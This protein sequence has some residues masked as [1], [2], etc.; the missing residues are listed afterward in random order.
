MY[1]LRKI[2]NKNTF[3]YIQHS[4]LRFQIVLFYN[5]FFVQA[6]LLSSTVEPGVIIVLML[7]RLCRFPSGT[8]PVHSLPTAVLS[9]RTQILLI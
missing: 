4:K 9:C 8:N 2:A 5:S 7:N 6:H 3:S 1:D